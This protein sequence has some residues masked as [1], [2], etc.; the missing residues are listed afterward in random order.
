MKTYEIWNLTSGELLAD[1]LNFEDLPELFKAYAEFY[2]GNEIIACY[3]EKPVIKRC[4]NVV[5]ANSASRNDFY[6]EWFNFME[7]LLT[8]DNIH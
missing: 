4:V 5:S 8:M 7:E 3:R 1:N 6:C 2:F